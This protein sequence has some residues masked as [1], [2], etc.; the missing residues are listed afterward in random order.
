MDTTAGSDIG[1][2]RSHAATGNQTLVFMFLASD[3]TDRAIPTL[4]ANKCITK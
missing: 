2:E 4:D 3:F 1:S